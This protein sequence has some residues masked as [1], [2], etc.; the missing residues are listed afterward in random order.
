MNLQQAGVLRAL[1]DACGQWPGKHFGKQ[2]EDIERN[3]SDMEVRTAGFGAKE[4]LRAASNRR[5][6]KPALRRWVPA[7][8]RNG[9]RVRIPFGARLPFKTCWL[10]TLPTRAS[11]GARVLYQS[12]PAGAKRPIFLESYRLVVC[13]VA[14]Y[15][16]SSSAGTGRLNK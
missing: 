12:M 6:L 10:K 13:W 2:R 9:P 3:H 15:W 14:K 7:L 16:A 8:Q 11:L 5:V 1:Q 4:V